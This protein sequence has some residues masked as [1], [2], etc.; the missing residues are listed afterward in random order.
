[1]KRLVQLISGL[2]FRPA[3]TQALYL[4]DPEQGIVMKLP[5]SKEITFTTQAERWEPGKIYVPAGAKIVSSTSEA[6]AWQ[7]AVPNRPAP[8][9]VVA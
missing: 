7:Q 3:D 5:R 1:M 9:E 8:L 6:A 4:V 2:V